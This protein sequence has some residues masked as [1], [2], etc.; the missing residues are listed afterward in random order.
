M[1]DWLTPDER[2]AFMFSGRR[3]S[4]AR[5]TLVHLDNANGAMS[6]LLA[7]AAEADRRIAALEAERGEALADRDCGRANEDRMV[8]EFTALEAEASD[9]RLAR[10]QWKSAAHEWVAARDLR[11]DVICELADALRE[12]AETECIRGDGPGAGKGMTSC[13]DECSGCK[14][15]WSAIPALARVDAPTR[16]GDDE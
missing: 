5:T 13:F 14:A 9:L 15:R 2:A 1:P 4:G 8:A 3:E 6:R 11:D 7:H 12:A 16:G 10:D